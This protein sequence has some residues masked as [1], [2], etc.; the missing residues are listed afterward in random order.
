MVHVSP[1]SAETLARGGGITN[2]HLIAYSL[3]NISAKNYQ[4]RL[5]CVEVIVCYIIVVFFETRCSGPLA[6]D[7]T[8]RI[9]L[10][11][12]YCAA[13]LQLPLP[14]TVATLKLIGELYLQL[15]HNHVPVQ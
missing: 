6:V 15:F 11:D 5:M 8:W 14:L 3:S 12:P 7:A 4:N 1:G 10:N 13:M 2:Y 9:R